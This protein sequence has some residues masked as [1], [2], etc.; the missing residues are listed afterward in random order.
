MALIENF[1]KV[2]IMFITVN[3][4]QSDFLI[5]SR[6]SPS[7]LPESLKLLIFGFDSESLLPFDVTTGEHTSLPF[8]Q[9]YYKSPKQ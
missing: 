2:G 5:Q 9:A 4:F 6:I 8:L 3:M 1:N 7:L